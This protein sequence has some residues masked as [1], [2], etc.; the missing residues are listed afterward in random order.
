MMSINSI[1]LIVLFEDPFWV[2]L[3]E[4]VNDDGYFVARTVFGAEPTNIELHQFLL[5]NF[6]A[7]KFSKPFNEEV[8]SRQLKQVNPK[9]R[10]RE[11]Q[12][13]L[14]SK[15]TVTKAHEAI[16]LMQEQVKT[17]KKHNKKLRREEEKMMKF[18]IKQ[19]KK[20][21]KKQGH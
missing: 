7:L 14:S 15:S 8:E 2:G 17:E 1:K 3:F 5:K 18:K 19:R 12:K 16:K 10:Q 21:E 11:A 6:D 9:R 4:R 13:E 20:K